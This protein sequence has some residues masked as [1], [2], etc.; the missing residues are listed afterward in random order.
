[1]SFIS[2]KTDKYV[3]NQEVYSIDKLE[4]CVADRILTNAKINIEGAIK[5]GKSHTRMQYETSEGSVFV[6][7]MFTT[8]NEYLRKETCFVNSLCNFFDHHSEY[9]LWLAVYTNQGKLNPTNIEEIVKKG[10]Y[11]LGAKNV[12]VYVRFC[13]YAYVQTR[14]NGFFRSYYVEE[15]R[16]LN[17]YK[18]CYDVSW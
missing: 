2:E 4:R 11:D 13:E 16:P 15:R 6:S 1:M 9:D 5:N 14:K 12:L 7:Q 3:S 8:T 17:K 10:L 18:I